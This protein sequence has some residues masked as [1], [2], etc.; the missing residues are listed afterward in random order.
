MIH[1]FGVFRFSI[2]RHLC[3][4]FVDGFVD[5]TWRNEGMQKTVCG[6]GCWKDSPNADNVNS[7][8]IFCPSITSNL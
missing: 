1:C 7:W 4:G 2:A 8:H 6:Q 3:H 5:T